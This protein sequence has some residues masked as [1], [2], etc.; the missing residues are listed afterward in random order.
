MWIWLRLLAGNMANLPERSKRESHKFTQT[1]TA[2]HRSSG[3]TKKG[4]PQ[5]RWP[6]PALPYP[7][8]RWLSPFLPLCR[9]ERCAV[10]RGGPW[11]RHRLE[12][13]GLGVCLRAE[14]TAL[15]DNGFCY[16]TSYLYCAWNLF[17]FHQKGASHLKMSLDWR[18]HL[19]QVLEL[20]FF[21]WS[22]I[23]K[24]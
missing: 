14:S 20:G 9:E 23:R 15:S 5:V 21:P 17:P 24:T 3:N 6:V 4:R 12:Q 22:K 8:A 7:A 18:S 19:F 1:N 10:G 16:H 11:E 13:R 2:A